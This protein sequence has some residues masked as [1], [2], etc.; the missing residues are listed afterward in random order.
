MSE[1]H[2]ARR[3]V[4][5]GRAARNER[6]IKT[7]QPLGRAWVC[8]YGS[9]GNAHHSWLANTRDLVMGEL[10]L[11]EL[12]PLSENDLAGRLR[13]SIK[14]RFDKFGARLGKKAKA[15]AAAMQALPEERLR[16][17]A[18]KRIEAIVVD[19]EEIALQGDEAD[20]KREAVAPHEVFLEDG[21]VG[22][23]IDTTLTDALI[24]EGFAREVVNKVQ[25]MRKEADF[26]VTDR[27]RVAI[28]T[29]SERLRAAVDAL[30]TYLEE[31]TLATELSFGEAH[32][33]V[34]QTWDING[35][36]AQIALSRVAVAPSLG[37]GN[38]T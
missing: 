1:M 14:L 3:A 20:V 25:F 22:I 28:D 23:L 29:P 10:N 38:G 12:L 6:G 26:H 11:K 4:A 27:I 5:L 18:R 24:V 37:K 31:E 17:Y 19:G 15:F 30:R 9:L 34:T 33:E 16:D 7:R 13:Y 2:I 8:A 35:E 36:S 32:G 21:G